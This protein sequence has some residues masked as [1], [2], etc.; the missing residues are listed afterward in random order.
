[1]LGQHSTH[2][3]QASTVFA[4]A[5]LLVRAA[6]DPASPYRLDQRH[7]HPYPSPIPALTWRLLM[8]DEEPAW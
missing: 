6:R 4:Q 7:G 3:C 2:Q 5:R 8:A 1:M